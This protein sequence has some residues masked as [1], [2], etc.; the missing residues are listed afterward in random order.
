[1][2]KTDE[3]KI[4]GKQLL[5]S[6]TSMSSNYRAACRGRSKQEFYAKLCIVVEE[7]DESIFW[8]ELFQES[9]IKNDKTSI[10][11]T[12]EAEE[13]LYIFSSAKKSTRNN[14]DR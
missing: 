2:P 14:L 12:R 4:L 8:L 9:D 5:R 11:L 13:F 1:M 3:A 6:G 10:V 7:I